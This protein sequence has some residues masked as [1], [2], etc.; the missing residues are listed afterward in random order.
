MKPKDPV[1]NFYSALDDEKKT[2]VRFLDCNAEVSAKVLRL[3][4]HCE[5][6][7]ELVKN[8]TKSK[9]VKRPYDQIADTIPEP[10]TPVEPTEVNDQT[11]SKKTRLQQHNVS[12]YGISTDTNMWAQHND[13]LAKTFYACNLPFII[14]DHPVFRQTIEMLR[15]GYQP[16]NRK[17]IGRPTSRQNP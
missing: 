15:P 17:D 12:S 14:A 5:K 2:S 4:T 10:S 8:K 3:R 7:P 16:P 1:W 9:P 6:C 13:Q 11:P